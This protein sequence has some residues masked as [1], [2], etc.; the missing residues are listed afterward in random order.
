MGEP[1]ACTLSQ[2]E[3]GLLGTLGVPAKQ[4]FLI[5]RCARDLT[6]YS[7]ETNLSASK[8]KVAL[9]ELKESGIESRAANPEEVLATL[10]IEDLRAIQRR[11]SL[12]GARSK[13]ELVTILE[14]G[15]VGNPDMLALLE[16]KSILDGK[17][18]FSFVW[19]FYCTQMSR[20]IADVIHREVALAERWLGGLQ[21]NVT[22]VRVW[23]GGDWCCDEK[24][25]L[26]FA[27]V[28]GLFPHFPGCRCHYSP[29]GRGLPDPE[30]EESVG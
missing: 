25:E 1:P 28:E 9:A 3:R 16:P 30:D 18:D 22:H 24:L 17:A 8:V 7:S 23:P 5:P 20:I 4:I 13:A 29:S 6:E 12:K 21:P 27:L 11:H 14:G 10:G 2:E 15:L 26:P 19:M